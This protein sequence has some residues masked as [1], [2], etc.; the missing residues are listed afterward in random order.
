MLQERCS[1]EHHG[2]QLQPCSTRSLELTSNRY[3]KDRQ[4]ANGAPEHKASLHLVY[5]SSLLVP[6]WI[7][8]SVL[9][10]WDQA[11]SCAVAP[12]KEIT[13]A[14]SQV[15]EELRCIPQRPYSFHLQRSSFFHQLS[16]FSAQG[17]VKPYK[18]YLSCPLS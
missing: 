10:Q 5:S 8:F 4:K 9:A 11:T 2:E 12:C 14:S 1:R 6:T 13:A 7:M 3:C 16:R 15:P 18:S 17:S